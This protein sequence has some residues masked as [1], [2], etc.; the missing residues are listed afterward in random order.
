MIVVNETTFEEQFYFRLSRLNLIIVLILSISSLMLGT[1]FLI[2]STPIK[3]FIP[4]YSSSQLR[5]EAIKNTFRL[6]S[7]MNVSIQQQKFLESIKDALL[8]GNYALE[9]DKSSVPIKTTKTEENLIS[10]IK[11]DSILRDRVIQEDKYNFTRSS[12]GNLID[13][14]FPPVKGKISQ[15]FSSDKKHFGVDIAVSENSPVKA[16]LD[17]RVIFAEWTSETGH[18][19]IIKHPKELTSIYKH[20]SAL[21]KTQGDIVSAGEVIANSGN[22][23]E[24]STGPHLHFELWFSGYPVDPIDFIDFSWD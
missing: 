2:S 11:E 14:L 10:Q 6:D 15:V 22:T 19:I 5:L 8:G 16:V 1:F 7:I 23:G 17:G 9:I 13:L 3:E 20:N 21:L 18:V 12:G 24:F 4:G